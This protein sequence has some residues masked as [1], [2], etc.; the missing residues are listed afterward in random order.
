MKT[1]EEIVTETSNSFF[2]WFDGDEFI[3]L[4]DETTAELLK[5]KDFKARLIEALKFC[6][7]DLRGAVIEDLND[8]WKRLDRIE[9]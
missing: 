4:N 1:Q 2:G 7:Y 6:F 3:E 5:R 8:I 9:Q